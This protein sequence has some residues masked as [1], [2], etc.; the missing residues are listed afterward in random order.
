MNITASSANN[1]GWECATQMSFQKKKEKKKHRAGSWE[2]HQTNTNTHTRRHTKKKYTCVLAKQP[3]RRREITD[4]EPVR[5][6][7][8]RLS[9]IRPDGGDKTNRQAFSKANNQGHF[10]VGCLSGS[11]K[12]R[13]HR[14][15]DDWSAHRERPSTDELTPMGA[16][17]AFGGD[18]IVQSF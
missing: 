16:L 11:Q 13:L 10:L 5:T 17:A 6:H 7:R 4:K 12:E 3:S 9:F 2:V 14:A 1:I 15:P 18:H 8:S